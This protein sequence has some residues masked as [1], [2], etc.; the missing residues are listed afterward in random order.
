MV[1]LVWLCLSIV[2]FTYVND[3]LAFTVS[4][5]YNQ[6]ERERMQK[7]EKEYTTIKSMKRVC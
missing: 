1:Q 3:V 5:W 4:P 2:L 6:K 7:M